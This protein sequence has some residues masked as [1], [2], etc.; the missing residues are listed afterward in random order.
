MKGL[1]WMHFEIIHSVLLQIP[2]FCLSTWSGCFAV[3]PFENTSIV[4]SLKLIIH[5]EIKGQF[6]WSSQLHDDY[7][8][9]AC[10]CDISTIYQLLEIQITYQDSTRVPLKSE[11]K[12][13][14]MA[15]LICAK[16]SHTIRWSDSYQMI[17]LTIYSSFIHWLCF[18]T[19][20]V[21]NVGT[22]S[23]V[24]RMSFRANFVNNN[25]Y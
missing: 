19:W 11:W 2:S 1:K 10:L 3:S 5:T 8:Y 15:A 16:V 7:K 18:Q 20:E 13:K 24:V 12:L 23:W 25:S 4:F 17:I 14:M 21:R 9:N 22:L 6:T